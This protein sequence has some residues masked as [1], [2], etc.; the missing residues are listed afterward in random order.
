MDRRG[1]LQ[2][3]EL[4]VAAAALAKTA[5]AQAETEAA[6]TTPHA[7]RPTGKFPLDACSRTLQWLRTPRD[8]AK[9]VADIGLESVDLTV[10]P[11]RDM[12]NPQ[13]SRPICQL[14]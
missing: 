11:I 9:A 13:G 10:S 4:T 5:S 14:S 12:S 6:R 7:S 2:L 1:F 3:G 8:L